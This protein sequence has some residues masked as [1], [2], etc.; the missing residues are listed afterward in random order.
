MILLSGFFFF[1]FLIVF[2]CVMPLVELST[3]ITLVI[4]PRTAK[5]D[6]KLSGGDLT[7]PTPKWAFCLVV[8][9]HYELQFSHIAR[10][11]KGQSHSRHP[12]AND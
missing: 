9:L 8:C 1:F 5:V 11:P 2:C 7:R 6:V 3:I 10:R 4:S 12:P